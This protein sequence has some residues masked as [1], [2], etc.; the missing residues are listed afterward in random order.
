MSLCQQVQHRLEVCLWSLRPSESIGRFFIQRLHTKLRFLS[1]DH[2]FPP[3]G[4]VL[5]LPEVTFDPYNQEGDP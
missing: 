1:V 4:R 2:A 3:V 5:C